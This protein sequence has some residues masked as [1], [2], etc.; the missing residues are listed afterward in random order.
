MPL[1]WLTWTTFLQCESITLIKHAEKV[2]TL[3][4]VS[5]C[6]SYTK[7]PLEVKQG[8]IIDVKDSQFLIELI[9]FV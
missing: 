8:V 3:E 7:C 5:E 4:K 9:K 2:F 6:I 1:D